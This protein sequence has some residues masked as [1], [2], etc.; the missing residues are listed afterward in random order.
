MIS[1]NIPP[2]IFPYENPTDKPRRVYLCEDSPE[3]ILTAI[4][5]AWSSR[6]GHSHNYIQIN[7][8][9]DNNM[10]Y[11]YIDIIPDLK[12]AKSIVT[13]IKTKISVDFYE[14]VE[15]CLLSCDKNRADDIYRLIILGFSVG[16]SARTYL[17]YPAIQR[18]MKIH[19]NVWN[20]YHHYLGFIRFEELQDK[21]LFARFRPHNNIISNIIPHFADRFPEENIMIVDV[22]RNIVAV[23]RHGLVGYTVTDINFDRITLPTSENEQ[24]L[25]KMW[26]GFIES[27]EIKE[28]ANPGLQR[29]NMPLRFREFTTEFL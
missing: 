3:G 26:K 15:T 20:E 17:A 16:P 8:C 22:S 2:Q 10:F 29:Q 12:K 1:N 21:T 7:S 18:I 28:R 11:E 23:S 24:L 27:I 5:D 9:T 4:Y 19:K 14:L 13:S 25:K 6:Y